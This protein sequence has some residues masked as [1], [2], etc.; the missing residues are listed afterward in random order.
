[1]SAVV[2]ACVLPGVFLTVVLLGALRP[3]VA[4]PLVPPTPAALVAAVVLLALLVRSGAVAPE[5]LMQTNRGALANMNGLVVLVTLFVASAEVVTLVVPDNGV[6]ALVG[7]TVLASLLAQALVIGPDRVR[8]LRGLL[9]T[10]GAAFVL[11]FIMLAAISSPAE[12]RVARALQILFEGVTL[13]TMTQR[14][15]HPL[16]AYLAFATLGLYLFG[17]AWLPSAAWHMV[18]VGRHVQRLDAS[19]ATPRIA[20]PENES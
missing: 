4:A 14:P 6:P 13:G 19:Q 9:V 11:K 17:V 18:R 16:E 3:G 2:E 10:F 8:L 12:S 1:V 15:P 5:R 7:W 20:G